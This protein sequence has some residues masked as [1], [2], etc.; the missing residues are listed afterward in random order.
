MNWGIWDRETLAAYRAMRDYQKAFVLYRKAIP[1][2]DAAK[3]N[4][5][6]AK[7]RLDFAL[8]NPVVKRHINLV[9]NSRLAEQQPN[10]QRSIVMEEEQEV[11]ISLSPYFG[12]KKKRV[13]KIFQS[14]EFIQPEHLK[15]ESAD[16]L[17][18]KIDE[19]HL[20][21]VQEIECARKI[22]ERISKKK[23]KRKIGMGVTSLIFASGCAVA[24][25]YSLP[26]F[27]P[28]VASYFTALTAL[29]QAFRDIVGE[30]DD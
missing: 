15:M 4:L 24:N 2:V 19:L 9:M 27:P 16:D 13:R 17:V 29:H 30:R 14:T 20:A 5:E 10:I 11:E 7:D 25:A 8:K 21:L 22:P 23:R 3:L 26:A 18:E 12:L 1:S 28:M 6:L